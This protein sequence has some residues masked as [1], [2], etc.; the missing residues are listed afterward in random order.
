VPIRKSSEYHSANSDSSRVRN[1][2]K[3]LC[4]GKDDKRY[5]FGVQER[6]LE[7]IQDPRMWQA[8]THIAGESRS[9]KTN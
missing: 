5:Q 3:A 1:L 2:V 6:C 7:I 4:G 9:Q 8:I